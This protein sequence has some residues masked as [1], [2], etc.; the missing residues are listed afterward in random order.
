MAESKFKTLQ[1]DVCELTKEEQKQSEDKIC[2]TCVPNENY[3][4]P[5]W[6]QD[7]K[8]FLNEK[9]CE[10]MVPVTLNSN[11]DFYTEKNSRPN[12]GG[13]TGREEIEGVEGGTTFYRNGEEMLDVP[14]NILLK[15]YIR[16]GIRKLLRFYNKYETDEIVCASVLPLEEALREQEEREADQG[17][18]F[19]AAGATLGS[20]IGTSLGP[21][22]TAA[23]AAAGAIIGGT[24]GELTTE[25][26]KIEPCTGIFGLDY[27]D[28]IEVRE[29]NGFETVRVNNA[30]RDTFPEIRN[31]NA[32]ELYGR[33]KDYTFVGSNKFLMV[34]V[35]IPAYIFDKTPDAPD[36]GSVKTSQDKVVFETKKFIDYLKKF[37]SGM[38]VFKSYQAYFLQ[39]EM[40]QLRFAET[41]NK[42]YI[43]F[44][45]ESRIDKFID[46]LDL[47]LENNGF[48]FNSKSGDLAFWVGST[49][50]P[51]DVE[52]S[53]DKSDEAK[54]FAIKTVR[55]R[56][57]DCPYV[58]C[59]I[60]LDSFIEYSKAD[61]TMMGY[62][63]ELKQINTALSANETPPWLDFIVKY[64]F[65]QLA[66]NY[67]SSGNFEDRN[68]PLLDLGKL[69]DFLL[70]QTL[71]FF[72][73]VA[74]KMNKSKCK[75]PEEIRE[76]TKD[77]K[78]LTVSRDMDGNVAGTRFHPW[79]ESIYQ[80]DSKG[81][82]KYGKDGKP[83]F[84]KQ[85][86]KLVN[87][88]QKKKT[89]PPKAATSS[90]PK[91]FLQ[92]LKESS[93]SVASAAMEILNPCTIQ[94]L[95]IDAMKCVMAALS[96]DE[97]Y[98]ILIKKMLESAGEEALELVIGALP[99]GKQL[100]IRAIVKREFG[101]MPM[102][103]EP[104]WDSGSA[105]TAVTRAATEET[106]GKV[107]KQ[108]TAEEESAS[109]DQQIEILND[110]I[111]E[112]RDPNLE[113][114]YTERLIEKAETLEF[115]K[116]TKL[117][118]KTDLLQ[119]IE[120]FKL[121]LSVGR[122]TL[123]TA[124]RDMLFIQENYPPTL[125][126]SNEDYKDA[127]RRKQLSGQ[128]INDETIK[129]A[130]AERDVQ[131]IEE[132][133]SAIQL[134]Q[135][136]LTTTGFDQYKI[137]IEEEVKRIEKEIAALEKKQ[138]PSD[139]ALEETS[140]YKDWESKTPEEQQELIEEQKKKAGL[141]EL[142]PDDEIRQG[143]LG[144]AVGNVQKAIVAAYIDAI[145]KTATIR[146]LQKAVENIPGIGLL[147][148][149]V[150]H[151]KCSTGPLIFPPIES[152]MN[153]L[154]LD[155]CKGGGPRLALP[156]LQKFPVN[157]NFIELLGSSLYVALKELI[158]KI[159]MA[160]IMKLGALLK[161]GLCRAI[162]DLGKAV[163]EG[164][165][166]G[167]VAELFCPDADNK[168]EAN[169]AVLKNSGANP[170]T[171]ANDSY[172]NLAN[173][174]S[175]SATTGEIK[176]AMLGNPRPGF[177]SGISNIVKSSVPEFSDSFADEDA[178]CSFF[179]Q[180]GNLLTGPQFNNLA[181]QASAETD[182]LP[183]NDSIC[184]TN[185]EKEQWDL[186]RMNAFNDSKLGEEFVR[187]QNEKARSDLADAADLLLNGTNLDQALE[188]ALGSKDPDCK[189]QRSVVPEMPEA[190]KRQMSQITDGIFKRLEKAFIDDTIEWNL[191]NPL[192]PPG[193]LS[194]ILADK[195]NRTFN[196]YNL[197]KKSWIWQ[198]LLGGLSDTPETVALQMQKQ[199]LEIDDSYTSGNGT[200][201][202]LIF[203]NGLEGV[204]KFS[205]TINIEDWKSSLR[206][207]YELE[208]NVKA[209]SRNQG[210]LK[211]TPA[212]S[213]YSEDF[214]YKAA[215]LKSLFEENWNKFQNI[216]ISGDSI[217]DSLEGI[218]KIYYGEF[219]KPL[220]TNTSGEP[221][222]G[223]QFGMNLEMP[224]EE[225]G[226]LTYVDPEPGSTEYTYQE[227]DRVLGR[228]LTNNPR[229]HF[230]DPAING[231]SFVEPFIWID[232]A[233][234]NGWMSFT[235]VVAPDPGA[236]ND[237]QTFLMVD[238]ITA[239]IENSKRSIKSHEG[240]STPPDCL[241]ELPF[242]RVSDS[243]TLATLEGIVTATC[244]V[245]LSDFLIRSF[246]I[247]ANLDLDIR[248][249]GDGLGSYIANLM[250]NEMNSI[251]SFWPSSYDRYAYV[252]LFLEQVVQTVKRK[253]D[254]GKIEETDEI[255]AALEA[256][257]TAQEDY[258][259]VKSKKQIDELDLS[260]AERNALTS[261]LSEEEFEKYIEQL[262]ELKARI[263]EGIGFAAAGP[264]WTSLFFGEPVVI[265]PL[266]S[267]DK[268]RFASK[269]WSINSVFSSCIV[270]FKTL[271]TLEFNKYS[272][273]INTSLTP[274]P[275]IYDV[276]RFFIGASNITL[277][278]QIN[279]GI[280]DIEIPVGGGQSALDYGT[281]NDCAKVDMEH[282]L[283]NLTISEEKLTSLQEN[284]GFYLEKYLVITEKENSKLIIPENLKGTVNIKE[285][286]RF[287][288]LE[289]S[290][291]DGN[292]PV[293]EYLGDATVS[294][295]G[296]SYEGSTGIKFGVRL[297]FVPP[298]GFNPFNNE[299]ENS[300]PVARK[301]RSY[302]LSKANI[303][304][305][306]IEASRYSFPIATFEQDVVDDKFS[307]YFDSDDN[308][309]QDL[310]CYI[311]NLAQ[312]DEFIQLMNNIIDLRKL[313]TALMIY[314]YENMLFSLGV[315]DTER[316][317][318][319][320]DSVMADDQ[321]GAIFNDSK[322]QAWKLF[323][324]YYVNNDRDPPWELPKFENP[325]KNFMKGL[326][327]TQ[328]NIFNNKEYSLD[329]RRR[330][331]KTN[332]FD[333]DGNPCKN[334]FMKL[335]K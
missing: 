120:G 288:S 72:D 101:D 330:I 169:K 335:F 128:I 218:N 70:D 40:G 171:S 2:P 71:D 53:F 84:N 312:T 76:A 283:N 177:C 31:L 332:P 162:G 55:A 176:D 310:K 304:G 66:V 98:Q 299:A 150:S 300:E 223:F 316:E 30:I 56:F 298:T 201:K 80:Y 247:F 105:D 135:N 258:I 251:T 153:T 69:D 107:K 305:I 20:V 74:Y 239:E 147:T 87:V 165:F 170:S 102:P 315:D 331:K 93:A 15:S 185:E 320:D 274:R 65:P 302:L 85:Y 318:P 59:T 37:K 257:N 234:Y 194:L 211:Y 95:T 119:K 260:I 42:F 264:D 46:K 261:M 199:I 184:L 246:P 163:I 193:I 273:K 67:G 228:S 333:K 203:N 265:W 89:K 110:R 207:G 224:S 23:G 322:Q 86:Q 266:V 282:P 126:S 4:M 161:G 325:Y 230:L 52:I 8:P 198:F 293:S 308:F 1:E 195:K 43:K 205:N 301:N 13:L 217:I 7:A 36:L 250:A 129:I 103:W 275:Y 289:Q 222:Q 111:T 334:D 137:I 248:N 29:Y 21:L 26:R 62:I 125:W 329:V 182:E 238:E 35:A 241:V 215:S 152:F 148:M 324:S 311:D 272:D 81:K 200:N 327:E 190:Q 263:I 145:M 167:V 113:N 117:Q 22:G 14:F 79:D 174:L 290:L 19:A 210:I 321:R 5:D 186:D 6:T 192:N 160:L 9:T 268:A 231:G 175:V 189:I 18:R 48:D 227:E 276:N 114:Q 229:V 158:K 269:L 306:S 96:L 278:S 25:G 216:A 235:N 12:I 82:V 309:N 196:S 146:E 130:S 51:F 63:A 242:D 11:A 83:V 209:R 33:V 328:I 139:T 3:I 294:E 57:K 58:D 281:V 121:N 133:V 255:L 280:Y 317:S 254:S 64:T 88:F 73:A 132:Q 97:A 112:L 291:I 178:V 142:K 204:D 124:E 91:G 50:T 244:R 180:M 295:D 99:A 144:K 34:L 44:Y 168:D 277:G 240:I 159:I 187:K 166:E 134:E 77:V 319:S 17:A 237:E 16:P 173:A 172:K 221:S 297:C 92:N 202:E 213:D 279:S 259:H 191:F 233:E 68:C 212:P 123:E 219:A 131:T 256:C 271:L 252:L 179:V 270:L 10:Y 206:F 149:F 109:I 28:F 249:F 287:L 164:G 39:T 181:D 156:T 78:I 61:Q 197:S 214:P 236:C 307:N 122:T 157:W 253:V 38:D 115:E 226:D 45:A 118:Q 326:R 245:Y 41:N 94:E 54:P 127:L 323:V 104:G 262:E 208:A 243:N 155:P 27:E 285:F 286:Q 225:A 284:G 143:T 232:P 267:I 314:S 49:K 136:S 140:E 32:L 100:E 60:G 296:A 108:K 75:S 313:P 303:N 138:S 220:V 24:V 106:E 183:V 90:D 151:F 188:D 116:L 47:L 292:K 141:Y 154:T